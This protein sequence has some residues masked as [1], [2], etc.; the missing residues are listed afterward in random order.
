MLLVLFLFCFLVKFEYRKISMVVLKWISLVIAVVL[1]LSIASAEKGVEP[2]YRN[3]AKKRRSKKSVPQRRALESFA[4]SLNS[5]DYN[6]SNWRLLFHSRTPQEFFDQYIRKLSAIYEKEKAIVNFVMIGACDG[7]TDPTI[8]YR[9]NKYEH[10]RGVF[11]EPVE[12]NFRD[13]STFLTD[14]G[15]IDRSY[16][17]RAAA[18][19]HCELPTIKMERPMYEE[20][21]ASLPH[22]LRRQIGSILPEHRDH[23]RKEWTIEEVRCVTSSDIMTE[24]SEALRNQTMNGNG[25]N[26]DRKVKKKRRPHVLKV[27]DIFYSALLGV[28]A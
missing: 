19:H 27:T 3:Q 24:W 11:V 7:I 25:E 21:N 20:K 28:L 2:E 22:W 10:W 26:A 14:S 12:M 18:T 9:F 13:L 17:I 16:L 8:K 5:R 23:P 4:N 15:S 6:A 1:L